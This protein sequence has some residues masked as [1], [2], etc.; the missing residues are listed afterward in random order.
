MTAVLTAVVHGATGAQ[1]RP[2]VDELL[3]AGHTVRGVHRG[4]DPSRLPAGTLSVTADLLDAD[5]L[6]AAYAGADVVVVVLPGGAAPDV[7]VDQAHTILKALRNAQVPRAVF[8]PGGAVWQQPPGIPFLDARTRLAVSLPDAVPTATVIGPA[9]AL[10]ENFSEGWIVERLLATGELV[11]T[12]PA[13]AA[14]TPVA[15]ADIATVI[16]ALLN[17]PR[18]PA[19]VVVHGPEQVTGTGVA[20]AVAAHLGRPVTWTVVP[21]AEYLAGVA[22]GLGDQYAANIAALYGAGADVP[23]PDPPPAGTR[24]ITG[25]T[26]LRE[27]ASA[28]AW[29]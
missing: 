27:W 13:D 21:S 4:G 28:Q 17:E 5:A 6:T 24:H 10:M 3:A 18:V 7:A 19:R 14:M 9:T 11:S 1:G 23:P 29:T 20:A 26:G 25:T 22:A 2:V 15:M 12:A 16:T 8:N